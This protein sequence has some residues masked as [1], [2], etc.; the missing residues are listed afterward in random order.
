MVSSR[1]HTWQKIPSADL[2]AWPLC[3]PSR[4]C[5]SLIELSL[6]L[7][8]SACLVAAYSQHWTSHGTGRRMGGTRG[9]T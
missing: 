8:I 5:C 2:S 6:A 4:S 3:M 9:A 1:P 7:V